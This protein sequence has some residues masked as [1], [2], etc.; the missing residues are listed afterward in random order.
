M[1]LVAQFI[2]CNQRRHELEWPGAITVAHT[3]FGADPKYYWVSWGSSPEL[4]C[5]DIV[6]SAR[7]VFS[8]RLS[9]GQII[10]PREFTMA[11]LGARGAQESQS[12]MS[13]ARRVTTYMRIESDMGILSASFDEQ[14][15]LTGI[16]VTASND[17]ADIS[18]GDRKGVRFVPLPASR[19]GLIEVLGEPKQESVRD[20][21]LRFGY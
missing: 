7:P 20:K 6:C 4:P 11:A 19:D 1:L 21:Q 10:G 2:G 18:V 16:T 5:R 3:F 9:S 12:P 15:R 17:Q 14:R 8:V 13:P